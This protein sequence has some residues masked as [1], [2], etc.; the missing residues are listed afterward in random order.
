MSA[1][2]Q[3]NEYSIGYLDSGH[4]HSANLAELELEN[5][6]GYFLNSKDADVG[7][8]GTIAVAE[9][10]LPDATADWSAV[11]LYNLPGEKTW[12]I[13]VFSYAYVRV[14]QSAD[15]EV[16]ALLKVCL[17]RRSTTMVVSV[18]LVLLLCLWVWW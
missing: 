14:D 16:G 13:S 4:G 2:L 3:E 7:S 12:P 15:P 6:D 17:Y 11:N 9:Q 5:F 18:A 1:F 10:L 8:A